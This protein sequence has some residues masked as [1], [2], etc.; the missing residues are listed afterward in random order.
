MSLSKA[1]GRAWAD[2][3]YKAKLLSDPAA[4][5]A[6]AGVSIPAGTKVKVLED[7]ADTRHLVL[8]AAPAN[9]DELSTEALEKVVGGIVEGNRGPQS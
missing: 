9:M 1:I 6:E 5:L 3:G 2:P 4:A 8:P 7:T